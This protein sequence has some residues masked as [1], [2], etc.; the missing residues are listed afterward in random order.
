MIIGSGINIVGGFRYKPRAGTIGSAFFNG[1]D[2]YLTMTMPN[3]PGTDNFTIEWWSFI[4]SWPTDMNFIE[5]R[6]GTGADSFGM[7][8]NLVSPSSLRLRVCGTLSS[9]TLAIPANTWRHMAVVGVV[10]GSTRVTTL[11]VNGTE[12]LTTSQS[13]TGRELSRNLLTIGRAFDYASTPSYYSGYMSN[14]RYVKGI[15]V[16]TSDFLPMMNTLMR[17]QDFYSGPF[18]N[19]EA[20]TGT[21]TQI[22]LQTPYSADNLKNFSSYSVPITNNNGV[23]A[24]TLTPAFPPAVEY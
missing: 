13:T 22:L 6:V 18:Y 15:A 17:T 4:P 10:T 19:I 16:Y 8:V 11:Y 20:I 2:Q 7:A 9:T 3:A 14:F 12:T 24:S 21:Q 23:T 1:T 5:T